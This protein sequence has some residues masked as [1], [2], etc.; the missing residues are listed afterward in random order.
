LAFVEPERLSYFQAL[1]VQRI[2]QRAGKIPQRRVP[3][4]LARA[5]MHFPEGI[6]NVRVQFE[7]FS[8]TPQGDG[9]Q[10]I[11]QAVGQAKCP[12][13]TG[14]HLAALGGLEQ[15]VTLIEL[16]HDAKLRWR[17]IQFS[18]QRKMCPKRKALYRALMG[19]KEKAEELDVS[20]TS[21]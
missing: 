15:N 17:L 4:I 16:N 13:E 21:R 3:V 12:A 8:H 14:Q 10:Q 19:C 1:L 11:T 7:E 9:D 20:A 18:I 2:A 5:A 6:V